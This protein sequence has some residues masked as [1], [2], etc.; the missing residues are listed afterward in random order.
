[1]AQSAAI[2]QVPFTWEGTDRAGKKVKGKT[3]AADEAAVRAELR[4]QG[5][6]PVRVRKQSTLFQKRGRVTA[7]DIAILIDARETDPR[8]VV[9][10][11][12]CTG[13]YHREERGNVRIR[14][15][16]RKTIPG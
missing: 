6:V 16:R 8:L 1:M 3:V 15:G 12:L 10:S 13:S 9:E 14:K 5:V 11:M 4:R 7:A 2:K